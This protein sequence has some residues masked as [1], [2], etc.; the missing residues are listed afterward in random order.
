[1]WAYLVTVMSAV[2]DL[3]ADRKPSVSTFNRRHAR[4]KPDITMTRY[5]H[6]YNTTWP[7]LVAVMSVLDEIGADGKPS[8]STFNRNKIVKNGYLRGQI[9]PHSAHMLFIISRRCQFSTRFVPMESPQSPHS[10]GAKLAKHGHHRDEMWSS[11]V[12]IWFYH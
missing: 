4:P 8:I 7:Y 5:G 10:I 2:D 12:H 6:I 1:M 9:W 3:R 11:F